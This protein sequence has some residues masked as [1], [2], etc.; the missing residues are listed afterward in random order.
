M[1]PAPPTK[2][3]KGWKLGRSQL[4][5]ELW[6]VALEQLFSGLMEMGGCRKKILKGKED[7]LFL[8][9]ES[10][11]SEENQARLALCSG[12]RVQKSRVEQTGPETVLCVFIAQNGRGAWTLPQVGRGVS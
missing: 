9:W 8:S 6:E 7:P 1:L 12:E 11:I 10:Q 5:V 4:T 3:A 2:D